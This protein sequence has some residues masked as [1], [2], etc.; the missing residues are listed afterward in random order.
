MG[1]PVLRKKSEEVT[2]FNEELALL[3]DDMH[4][5]L[6]EAHGAGLAAVQIGVLKRVF[7]INVDDQEIEFVNPKILALKGTQVGDEGCL[8]VKGKFGSVKRYMKV[9]ITAFDR[10]GKKFRIKAK[11]FAARAIQHEY[12]HLDGIIYIDK[13]TDIQDEN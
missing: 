4:D 10:N 5:T 6:E 8:S 2:E 13:A 12:D 7:I 1:D 3:L 9:D 11:E